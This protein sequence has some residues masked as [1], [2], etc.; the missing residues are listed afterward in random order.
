MKLVFV[1]GHFNIEKNG[2]ETRSVPTVLSKVGDFEYFV[3]KVY[4]GNFVG[5]F[6]F[7]HIALFMKFQV[8]TMQSH[9]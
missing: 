9:I 7:S 2:V 5:I 1:D 8:N 4:L 6:H 3:E